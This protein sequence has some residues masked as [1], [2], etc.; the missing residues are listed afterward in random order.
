MSNATRI[1]PLKEDHY[2]SQLGLKYVD[3]YLVH[4]PTSI[5]GHD[6]KEFEKIKEDG[7]ARYVL[8]PISFNSSAA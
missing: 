4:Y 5:K 6:W 8:N 3:L 7:L 1:S 2:L